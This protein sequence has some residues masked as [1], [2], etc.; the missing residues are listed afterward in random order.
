MRRVFSGH[1]TA[2]R[3]ANR[4]GD[5]ATVARGGYRQAPAERH[6]TVACSAACGGVAGL[7]PGRILCVTGVVPAAAV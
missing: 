1:A 3:V 2:A 4:V 7:C 5:I 6:D